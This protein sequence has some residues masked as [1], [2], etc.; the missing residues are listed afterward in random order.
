MS[1]NVVTDGLLK[2]ETDPDFTKSAKAIRQYYSAGDCSDDDLISFAKT[3][4]TDVRSY[5]VEGELDYFYSLMMPILEDYRIEELFSI[6]K[7]GV[8]EIA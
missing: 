7:E 8:N 3:R 5:V 2:F 1:G 4:G 6:L